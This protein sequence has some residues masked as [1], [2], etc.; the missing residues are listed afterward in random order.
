MT[1][2][3]LFE[4]A[5]SLMATAA[6]EAPEYAPHAVAMINL[7]LA[8]TAGINGALRAEK[9]L[10]PLLQLP[11]IEALSQTLPCEEELCICALPYGLCAKMLPA[12]DE[13]QKAAYYQNLY[14]MALDDLKRY[15]STAVVDWYGGGGTV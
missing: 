12:E 10:A 13:M 15:E 8:Q 7:L 6:D 5:L 3:K 14:A 1:G 2:Q 11:Q 9:G 4:T